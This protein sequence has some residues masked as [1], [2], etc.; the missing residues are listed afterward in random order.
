MIAALSITI[1]GVL[2]GVGIAGMTGLR[3]DGVIVVPL[4]AMYSLYTF[5]ALPLFLANPKSHAYPWAGVAV[6]EPR[7]RR[8][9]SDRTDRDIVPVD[10]VQVGGGNGVLR[11]DSSG[12]ADADRTMANR[13][14]TRC[15]RI[16]YCNR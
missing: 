7:C 4:L 6:D 1:L 16:R 8:A 15:G 2:I 5:A 3:M 9:G 13:L 12:R 10:T 14:A 11:H